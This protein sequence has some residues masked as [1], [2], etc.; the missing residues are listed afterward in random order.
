MT[1]KYF[2]SGAFQCF[3]NSVALCQWILD[4]LKK[5]RNPMIDRLI[6]SAD[7]VSSLWLITLP[8]LIAIGVAKLDMHIFVNIAWSLDRWVTRLDGCGELESNLAKI[9]GHCSSKSGDYFFAYH[10]ITGTMSHVTRWVRLPHPKSQR[11]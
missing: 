6:G 8:S 11:L 10:V 3:L 1:K 7:G 2:K 9:G 4:I 5:A